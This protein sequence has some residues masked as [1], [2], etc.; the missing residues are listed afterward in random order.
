MSSMPTD[1]LDPPSE[2]YTVGDLRVDVGQQRVVRADVDI[3][4]PPFGRRRLS[5]LLS[6]LA[7]SV[8]KL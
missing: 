5:Q 6:M 7:F 8:Q 1:R 3:D 2:A 4:L